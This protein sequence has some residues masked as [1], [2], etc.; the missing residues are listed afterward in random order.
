MPDQE[1]GP[2]PFS[3]NKRT[4]RTLISDE[5]VPM[6]R[7]IAALVEAL[8]AL[9]ARAAK[10]EWKFLEGLSTSSFEDMCQRFRPR[11]GN[12]YT[13]L[14]ENPDTVALKKEILRSSNTG[15]AINIPACRAALLRGADANA[16]VRVEGGRTKS[17]VCAL[18]NWDE[19]RY[20][21]TAVE[22]LELLVEYGAVMRKTEMD[23]VAAI[24]VSCATQGSR[25][26]RVCR[27]AN[28]QEW[29]KAQHYALENRPRPP[30]R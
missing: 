13:L 25:L 30:R 24:W 19:P 8:E 15:A 4:L 12:M 3:P 7:R 23:T 18:M 11:D 2:G 21:D 9:V 20:I 1:A 14:A 29:S 22:G 10:D 6:E 26:M 5:G 28:E 17:L 27:E 16:T